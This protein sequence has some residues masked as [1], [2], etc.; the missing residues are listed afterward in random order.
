MSKREFRLDSEY[1]YNYESP[2]RWILSHLMR[3]PLVPLAILAGSIL[4][5]VAASSIQLLIGRAFDLITQPE[6]PVN[7]LLL[8]AVGV[9]VAALGRASN[10]RSM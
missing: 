8:L 2:V 6:W 4:N 9:F 3:Y 7:A 5:N 10:I 1:N